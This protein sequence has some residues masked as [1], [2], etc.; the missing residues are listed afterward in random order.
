M[1]YFAHLDK[2]DNVISVVVVDKE[3]IESGRLGDKKFWVETNNRTFY[4]V[5]YDANGQPDGGT[6]LRANYASIGGK[7]D[8]TNDVFYE[9]RPFA[10]WTISAPDWKWTPPIPKPARSEVYANVWNETTRS[11]D[12]VPR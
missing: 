7:Y 10:S 8:R 1:S 9:A 3:D 5:H 11:W 4:G 2:D 12:Q 6:P